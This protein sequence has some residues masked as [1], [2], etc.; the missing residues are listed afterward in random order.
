MIDLTTY[1]NPLQ[2]TPPI[3]DT[4]FKASSYELFM[5]DNFK[6]I[7]KNKEPVSFF[8]NPAQH[9]L[10]WHMQYYLDILVLKARKMGF[11]SDALGIAVTKF[12]MGHNEKCISMSFDQTASEKQLARAKYYINSYEKKNK[13]KIP[14]KYN[15]KNQMV[16]EGTYINKDGEEESFQNIL[17]VGTARNTDFGRGDDITFL[18]LTE[19]S[20]ADVLS[21]MAGVGEACLPGAHKIFETTAAG[22]NEYKKFWDAA[23][24]GD[25][26]FAALFYSP[27]WEYS[28]EY[29][30]KKRRDLGR[31][32]A[33]EFPLTALEAF[34]TS[35][36][37][38]FDQMA[39]IQYQKETLQIKPIEAQTIDK[40]MFKQFRKLN[41]GEFILVFIDTAGEGSDF[42]SGMFI[43]K[44]RLDIPIQLSYE[45]SIIDV[46]PALKIVLEW[47]YK[48][49]GVK[50]VVCYE[51]NNGG[52]YELERLSRLNRDQNYTIYYQ[53]KLNSEGELE[54]T[55]KMGWNTNTATRPVMLTGVEEL[56][57]NHL[58]TIYSDN[59]ATQM[60][61]FVK[62][63]TPSGWR[64][65]A[66]T[67][68]FDDD[69]MALAGA[70]QM[71]QTENPPVVYKP[72][73]QYKP[74]NFMV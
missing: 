58:V 21:L 14:Y 50:P 33:Q 71:Y 8:A 20:L 54:R 40:D 10:N 25:N 38:Y 19:V 17:Q 27:Y 18:H 73:Q 16:Y 68:S 45:G 65:E 44:N 24:R 52:G 37:P 47:I 43:S 64:A 29:V 26:D 31:L 11:S 56:V 34:L 62:K 30:E 59:T 72:Q 69:I 36:L 7:D 13:V 22:F 66:E 4:G 51:T 46:T 9:S 32:G 6:I 70:W 63:K 42:N 28:Q 12:L 15:S 55:D 41:S 35:G 2:N 39:M 60:F 5:S 48:E 61:S 74:T 67:G 3:I 49:T 1:P 53:Y 23:M 57:N